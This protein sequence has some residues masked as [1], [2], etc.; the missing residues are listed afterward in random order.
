METVRTEQEKTMQIKHA[1]A[2]RYVHNA[3]ETLQKAGKEGRLYMDSKYVSSACG[4]AYRG[5][6]IALD[7]WLRL[8]NVAM[9]KKPKRASIEFYTASVAKLDSKLLKKLNIVYQA[10][11]I[12]GYYEGILSVPII[13]EGF[14]TAYEIIAY[15]KP[16]HELT[17][18]ELKAIE[19]KKKPAWMRV[20][21]SFFFA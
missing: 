15:I 2:I 7:E 20:M 8:R 5:V 13:R 18:D 12:S 6:L 1:E 3:E 9:P 21:Y 16:E 14:D 17:P 4:I 11:H 10:L 19:A